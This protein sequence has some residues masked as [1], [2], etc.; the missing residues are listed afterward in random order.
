MTRVC[1]VGSEEC[2]L[3]SALFSRETA[4]DALSTYRIDQPYANTL[5][6]ETISLGAA[7]SL[8]NDLNWYLVR[9]TDTAIVLDSSV[10]ESEWLSRDLASAIRDGEIDPE[11]SDR[12]LMVYG[13]EDSDDE[14]HQQ[15]QN[16]YQHQRLV[17]PMFVART[18]ETL[19]EYDLRDVH[20]TL[21]VRITDEEF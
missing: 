1:L 20:E 21:V 11:E 7:V 6:L 4:R 2:D 19:P 8:L 12:Y 9:Y 14:E 16:Q 18:G 13:V 17:E 15:Q 3:R 10:S 5:S